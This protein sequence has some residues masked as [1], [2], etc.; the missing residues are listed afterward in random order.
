MLRLAAVISED[1]AQAGIV[2]TPG[3]RTFP[4]SFLGTAWGYPKQSTGRKY[5][6]AVCP[7]WLSTCCASVTPGMDTEIWFLPDV[8]TSAPETPSPLTRRFKM[9]TVS[10]R[11]AWDTLFPS[12]V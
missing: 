1:D 9:L 4:F 12:A 11:S 6:R 5:M 7:I 10:S 8:W 2:S 3:G